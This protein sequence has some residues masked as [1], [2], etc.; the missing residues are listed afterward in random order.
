M[1][2]VPAALVT[3]VLDARRWPDAVATGWLIAEG[4]GIG[5][6]YGKCARHVVIDPPPMARPLTKPERKA[7]AKKPSG[8]LVKIY[9][10]RNR[11]RTKR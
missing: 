2:R 10:S 5:V 7:I 6:H 4:M 1:P 11:A 9:M 3:S 8:S